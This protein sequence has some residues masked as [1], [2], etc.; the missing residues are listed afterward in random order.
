[1]NFLKKKLYRCP[2]PRGE[3]LVS[4]GQGDL[5]EQRRG[6]SIQQF[7]VFGKKRKGKKYRERRKNRSKVLRI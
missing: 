7:C 6:G 5:H 3:G 2:G 1:M 4:S